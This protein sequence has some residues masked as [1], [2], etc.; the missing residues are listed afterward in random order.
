MVG[1][2]S[3]SIIK[4][5]ERVIINKELQTSALN[6]SYKT[7][8]GIHYKRYKYKHI[9][10]A[11]MGLDKVGWVYEKEIMLKNLL[12]F[13]E[14]GLRIDMGEHVDVLHLDN[15]FVNSPT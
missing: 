2:I 4:K 8:D 3:N 11:L 14:N 13:G 6:V 10:K 1:G 7:I 15:V 12:E 9:W 5:K